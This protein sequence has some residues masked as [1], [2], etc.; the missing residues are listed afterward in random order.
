MLKNF[1][2]GTEIAKVGGFHI[3]NI[4][5]LLKENGLLEGVDFLKYG[6]ITLIAKKSIRFPKYITEIINKNKFTDL[7]NLL[8][9]NY[10]LDILEG[11]TK[12]IENKFKVVDILGKKFVDINDEKLFN[13]MTVDTLIKSV[14]DNSE[15][16][17]LIN[18]NYIMGHLKLTNKKSL[19]W[20]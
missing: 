14:I 16:Q 19:T 5:I 13:I 8:P 1:I 3:A 18:G 2:L 7:S 9:Q 11:N 12:L 10:F 17:E 4:S 6:G 20:Y 15:L